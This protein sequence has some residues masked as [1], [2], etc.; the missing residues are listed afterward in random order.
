MARIKQTARKSMHNTKESRLQTKRTMH[1]TI[2]HKKRISS[3]GVKKPKRNYR[4]GALALKQIRQYQRTTELLIRRA[5]FQRLCREVAQGLHIKITDLRFQAA[6]LQCL[7]EAAEAYI[8][9]L[10]EDTQL[11]AIHAKRVT[12]MPKDMQLARRIRGERN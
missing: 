8:V 3:D 5:P 1:K 4:P 11:L 7:Q 6:A 10:M 9:G 12:I 2:A